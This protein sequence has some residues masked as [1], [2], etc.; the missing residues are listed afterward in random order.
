MALYKYSSFP[1]VHVLY[2]AYT[3]KASLQCHIL[4]RDITERDDT[5]EGRVDFNKFSFDSRSEPLE[6]N[7]FYN[8][9]N[10]VFAETVNTDFKQLC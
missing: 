3:R 7:Q 2:A 6:N 5:K 8:D 4:Q 9:N 1:F 10:S